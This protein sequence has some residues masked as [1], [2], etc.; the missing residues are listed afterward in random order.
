MT[1]DRLKS[2]KDDIGTQYNNLANSAWVNER[3]TSL[4]AQYDVLIQLISEMESKDASTASNSGRS[5]SGKNSN[6]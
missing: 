4:K 2:L 3:L 1:L 6:K 5:K